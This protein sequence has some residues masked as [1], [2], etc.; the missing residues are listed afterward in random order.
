MNI[1]SI[2]QQT[3]QTRMKCS[4]KKES[5]PNFFFYK[6]KKR[7][8]HVSSCRYSDIGG[9]EVLLIPGALWSSMPSWK[10]QT[11]PSLNPTA[12]N[13]AVA[14]TVVIAP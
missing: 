11:D 10:Q 7:K 9:S 4:K 6:K 8:E 13:P 2:I 12:K 1:T 5:V 14:A 3:K